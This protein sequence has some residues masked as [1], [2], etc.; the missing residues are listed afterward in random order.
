MRLYAL[1]ILIALATTFFASKLLY[2]GNSY[3]TA[4]KNDI[5]SIKVIEY[6]LHRYVLPVETI[7]VNALFASKNSTKNNHLLNSIM[8]LMLVKSDVDYSSSKSCY[9][10]ED[11]TFFP[12]SISSKFFIWEDFRCNKRT[13]LPSGFFHTAP[14]IHPSGDSYALLAIKT[15][16]LPF[17]NDKWVNN[18]LSYFHFSD[19][20]KLKQTGFKI[21]NKIFDLLKLSETEQRYLENGNN[22]FISGK[23]LFSNINENISSNFFNFIQSSSGK[24][25]IYYLEEINAY[26]HKHTNFTLSKYS[27]RQSCLFVDNNLC[28]NYN[29]KHIF[30]ITK[31]STI[32]FFILSIVTIVLVIWTLLKKI[33]LQKQDEERKRLALQV[34]SHEFRTPISSMLLITERLN[35]YIYEM[36]SDVQED[37]LQISSNVYR[38]QRLTE[39][40]KNYLKASDKLINTNKT[41]IES[42]NQFFYRLTQN[43]ENIVFNKLEIDQS[44]EIDQY[45]ISICL[46]NLI[47]N[48]LNHGMEPIS[49]NL[50][51][52]K[53]NLNIS[54]TDNGK[55]E[56]ETL[57]QASGEFV[58]GTKSEGSGLGLNIV[59]KVIYEMDGTLKL[60]LNPTTFTIKLKNILKD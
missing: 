16:R 33:K 31:N 52:I 34:L 43:F 19:I 40:S 3:S 23:H 15:E 28:W 7:N 24:Y 60:S 8:Q 17:K 25:N 4:S 42:I 9:L 48:A 59:K 22:I 58:K 18:N 2:K 36:P 35:K 6:G 38:L 49:V 56:F 11:P 5:Q 10:N 54:V 47:E 20:K 53:N 13:T 41:N 32:I 37:L 12:S 44:A 55:C 46:K 21:D 29:I 51:V 1:L 39:T 14:F 57:E 30:R 26:L 45:W 27:K 50:S